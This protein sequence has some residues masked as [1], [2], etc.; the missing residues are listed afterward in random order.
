MRVVESLES[1]ALQIIERDFLVTTCSNY[2]FP[3]DKSIR[4]TMMYFDFHSLLTV[5][6]IIVDTAI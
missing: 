2:L 4:D 6:V 5:E 1:V 3:K